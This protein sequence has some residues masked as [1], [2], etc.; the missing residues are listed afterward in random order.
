[1]KV[2]YVCSYGGSGSK[3]LC[4][5]LKKFGKV[6][7]IHS[8]KPPQKLT[9]IG[10]DVYC[11][12]FNNKVI[13]DNEL[14]NYYVIYIYKNPIKS[15][16]SRFR[17]PDHLKHI[18]CNTNIKLSD[19]VKSQKDLYGIEEFFDNYTT[20]DPDRNYK[21]YCVK[22]EDFFA[23]ISDFNKTLGIPD[24]PENYPRE[25]TTRREYQDYDKLEKIYSNLLNKMKK[26]DFITIV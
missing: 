23:N 15:V 2:F 12:W 13:P 6:E 7:H 26:M 3:I 19:V 14:V 24:N 4:E 21:I 8:R 9:H 18:Q 1:M 17:N 20:P 5:Y 16:Y 11:E 22:Y 25:I 10:G